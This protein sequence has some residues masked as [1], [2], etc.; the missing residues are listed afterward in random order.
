MSCIQATPKFITFPPY[1]VTRKTWQEYSG[2]FS[3]LSISP[4]TRFW[5]PGFVIK[6][7]GM[8]FRGVLQISRADS[9]LSFYYVAT[10]LVR[11]KQMP[12]VFKPLILLNS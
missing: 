5:F 11:S 9:N 3:V 8:N 1:I 4:H 12:W 7:I 10:H 2:C 6:P